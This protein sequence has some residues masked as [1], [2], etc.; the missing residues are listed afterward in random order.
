MKKCGFSF[1]QCAKLFRKMVNEALLK[2]GRIISGYRLSQRKF[3][4]ICQSKMFQF[5]PFFVQNPIKQKIFVY[6]SIGMNGQ[7]IY[8]LWQSTVQI[9]LIRKWCKMMGRGLGSWKWFVFSRIYG[10]TGPI[11]N[12]SEINVS[13]KNTK[14][15]SFSK[16]V[17]NDNW[18]EF[19]AALRS[20]IFFNWKWFD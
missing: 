1:Q 9:M 19:P 12:N 5:F 6:E 16:E 4:D 8:Y 14:V 11:F 18:T 7:V 17:I 3:I 10:P 20:N 13:W 15:T 2:T